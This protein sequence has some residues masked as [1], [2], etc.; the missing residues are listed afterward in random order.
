MLF[1]LRLLVKF[2]S[3]SVRLKVECEQNPEWVPRLP[4][5]FYSIVAVFRHLFFR[6]MIEI[7]KVE[8]LEVKQRTILSGAK[9]CCYNMFF[10]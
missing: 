7:W 8:E 1:L 4:N 10:K 5:K 2:P 6:Q 3:A 9:E